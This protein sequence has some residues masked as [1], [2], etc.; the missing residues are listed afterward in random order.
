MILVDTHCHIHDLSYDWPSTNMVKNAVNAGVTKFICIGTS[1]KD[2]Q[3]ATDFANK[4]QGAWASVGLYP[5]ESQNWQ[6]DIT[7]L[8]S[9]TIRSKV[10]AIGEC[11]LDYYY[12][13]VSKSDQINALNAQIKLAQSLNL[14]IIFHVREA[15]DDL[16]PII[17]TYK[18]LKGV[19]HSFTANYKTAQM[20]LS[21]GF[22]IGLNGII[23]FTKDQNQLH[24]AK[25]I[26]LNKILLETDAPFLTP[27]PIRGTINEPKNI[28]VI[29]KYL[30]DLRGESIKDLAKATSANA[31]ELFGI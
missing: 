7:K 27:T 14:P 2:S 5:H 26:P 6:K 19:F 22:Y 29:A 31:A 30:S 16:W 1:A 15:F 8:S 23:T 24:M 10:V 11:G 20:V 3:V 9:L 12:K 13:K 4:T 25:N 28:A 21:R 18:G 17:D